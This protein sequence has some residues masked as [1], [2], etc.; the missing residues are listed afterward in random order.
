M[1]DT[2]M[3]VR[4]FDKGL[5]M[6]IALVTGANRGLG[7]ETS[8]QLALK[9]MKVYMACRKKEEGCVARDR[10]RK[11]GL[12]VEFVKMDVTKTKDIRDFLTTIKE[13]HEFVDILINNA[14]VFLESDGPRDQRNSSVLKVDPII[15]LKTIEANTLGPLK[16][17]Q[18]I[19]PMMLER[20][21]GRVINVSSGMGQL[22]NMQGHWPGYR[23]SKTALNSLT[24]I[25]SDEIKQSNIFVNSVCPGWVRTDMGGNEANLSVEEGVDTIVWLATCEK[26]PKGKFLRNK[27]P[28]EW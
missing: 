19:I 17:I 7:F 16:L 21:E 28:I 6:K 25:L 24:Q 27:E 2:P 5:S 11:E 9:G 22:Q 8:R 23:M 4:F 3:S 15:I 26:S 12:N 13:N 1:D 18:S 14:G 10:L 20:D